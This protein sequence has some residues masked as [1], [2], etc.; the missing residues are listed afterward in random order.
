MRERIGA[1]VLRVSGV[2]LHPMP[3]DAVRGGEAIEL[4]PQVLVLHRLLVR[5]APTAAL[6]VVQP[7]ADAFLHV[8][9]IGVDLDMAGVLEQLQRPYDRRELHAIVGRLRLTAEQLPFLAV[10]PHNGAPASGPG[11]ALA[12]AIGIDAY[13]LDANAARAFRH[14]V[15]FASASPEPGLSWERA[16]RAIRAGRGACP[17]CA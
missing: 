6:P 12:G 11:I 14:A 5:G 9:R 1:L 16:C 10:H 8:L 17:R 15:R 2:P 3:R 7:I 4:P 13:R